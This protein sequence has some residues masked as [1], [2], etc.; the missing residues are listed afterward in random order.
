MEK[1]INRG[2]RHR[3]KSRFNPSRAYIEKSIDYYL[4][5]GGQIT[6][7]GEV[8]SDPVGS[9]SPWEIDSFFTED[10]FSFSFTEEIISS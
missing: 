10:D 4:N 3:K 1:M 6:R 8:T 9:T 7:I 5:H 2:M